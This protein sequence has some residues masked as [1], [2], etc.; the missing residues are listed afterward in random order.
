MGSSSFVVILT[1]VV[2]NKVLALIIGPAGLGLVGLY[3]SI[4]SVVA[5]ISGMGINGSGVRH[6]A[7]AVSE[8]DNEK[9]SITCT[10]VRIS[11]FVFGLV[12]AI[13][14]IVFREQVSVLAI[15]KSGYG[16]VVAWLGLGV[17]ATNVSNAQI[18]L[19]NGLRKLGDLARINVTGA[20]LGLPIACIAVLLWKTNGVIA[21]LVGG[22][23]ATLTASWWFYN[24]SEIPKVKI[25]RN[26]NLV[27]V[28]LRELLGLGT[29]LMLSALMT[30]SVQ[31]C[32]RA[33]LSQTMGIEATGHFQASWSISML[34]LGFVL[35]AMATDFYPRLSMVAKDSSETNNL[36]NEQMEVALLLTGPVI[37]GML[38]FTPQIISILYSKAFY[39]T[40]SI[41][42]WQ[43]LGDLFKVACWP[44]GFILLAHGRS[45]LFFAAELT[46]NL[47]YLSIIYMG[48]GIWGVNITGIAFLVAYILLFCVNWVIVHRL[49]RFRFTRYN[50]RL[51]LMYVLC[52]IIVYCFADTNNVMFFAMS[53][54]ITLALGVYSIRRLCNSVG[55][56]PWKKAKATNCF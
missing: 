44:M 45:A 6:I 1:G 50:L 41:L 23:L 10:A 24:K 40:T 17:L 39:E 49:T 52:S 27:L 15:G 47:A 36:V 11:S 7:A 22:N 31:F 20:L 46:W 3:L 53:L 26:W 43:I 35:N 2:K 13:S 5:T 8:N 33:Y 51:L 30:A 21:A 56:L 37:L 34:Y 19:L 38:S 12:G 48:L 55:P 54:L 18:S 16:A 29:V 32:V 9:L 42:R 14:L 4:I 28:Q 25:G